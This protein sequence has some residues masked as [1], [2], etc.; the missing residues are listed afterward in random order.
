[1]A[2][3]RYPS[4]AD[5]EVHETHAAV[6]VLV[7]EKAFK[8]KKPVKFE[9]LDFSTLD[10]R[11][12]AIERELELNRRLA[13]EVYEGIY[14]IC[15]ESGRVVEYALVMKRMPADRSIEHLAGRGKNL[16]SCLSR[17]AHK[18]ADF[19]RNCANSASTPAIAAEGRPERIKEKW[20]ENFADIQR[21]VPDVVRE[22]T[23]TV[24]KN[25]AFQY[26]AGRRPLFYRRIEQG[27]IKDGHGDLLAADIFCLDSGPEVLDCIEFDD[28]YR[29]SDVA[30]EV[31][32][33]AMDLTRLGRADDARR[34][35]SEYAEA[36]AR[37][38]PFTLLEHYI[39]YRASVRTK[40]ACLSYEQGRPDSAEQAGS[41]A[42]IAKEHACRALPLLVV[43]GG[44]PGTGKSSLAQALQHLDAFAENISREPRFALL[45]SDEV[46]KELAGL[47]P[48]EKSGSSL[49]QGIYSR[50]FTERTY[51]EMLN[52][53]TEH[54]GMGRSVILDA[55]FASSTFRNAA[56]D[57]AKKYHAVL[58]EIC[59]EAPQEICEARIRQRM[60]EI[61]DPSEAD[62]AVARAVR[63]SFDD[64]PTAVRIETSGRADES[65]ESAVAAI[66][67]ITGAGL[68]WI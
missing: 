23:V 9:F 28:R 27:E 12:G 18:L 66:E 5:A 59:C 44:S 63:A 22:D 37:P 30:S 42:E 19:H 32:F 41:L 60:A 47:K 6:V 17:L 68:C 53:A 56:A 67:K 65:L 54:L 13:P 45:R 38:I 43:I 4:T 20:E 1:M 62:E 7:G 39:A 8:I 52:R 64:W 24:A 58:V 48:E 51:G 14:S 11:R 49:G 46:R 25:S 35:I 36:F 29:Y 50:E 2:R 33:L 34:F 15:D 40:V 21:F 10:K 26:L 31:A 16:K 3:S 61:T 55:T 57:V